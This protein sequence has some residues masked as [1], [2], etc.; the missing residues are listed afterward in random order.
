VP[1]PTRYLLIGSTEAYSGKSAT[2]LGLAYQ[3]QAIGLD[4]AYGK[5]L[6]TC[7]SESPDDDIDEDVR[8]ITGLLKLPPD[9]IQPTLL[10]LD[11]KRINNRLL[12]E[13]TTDYYQSLVDAP[14]SPDADLVILEG[15]GTLE[16]G[17]LFNLS[18]PQL[19][20][21]VDASVVLV[22]RYHS[23]LLVDALIAAQKVLGDR[24]IGAVINDV[25]SKQFE[26][27]Q[28]LVTP[29]LESRGINVLGLL[30]SSALLRSVSVREIVQMLNAEVLC[31]SERLD[32]LVEGIQIGA[33]GV[34]SAVRYFNQAQHMAIITGGD[35][36]D[37]QLAALETSTHCLIL[38]GHLAPSPLVLS[39]AEEVEI[40]VLSVD[41]DTLET[42]EILDRTFGQ[43]RLNDSMKVEY[44]KQMMG[45]YF[46]LD[47]LLEKLGMELTKM[48]S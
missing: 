24:L 26:A 41:L 14:P 42:V 3:L 8:F 4:L 30:P 23:V 10:S 28:T 25:P 16:E 18:L 39:R 12:A 15:P 9:R 38:T 2:I 17:S 40:P 29:F 36:T 45:E 22:C 34:S 47:R 11:A 7:L 37:I 13:D 46:N 32:L 33:M 44:V 1:K 6:G 48:G 43:V 20:E 21:A 19:A 5:P 27:T 31:G 35:R